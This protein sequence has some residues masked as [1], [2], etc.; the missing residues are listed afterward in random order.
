LKCR[1]QHEL[2]LCDAIAFAFARDAGLPPLDVWY[3]AACA[4]SLGS[5]ALVCGGGELELSVVDEPRPAVQ[6]RA[7]CGVQSIGVTPPEL[8]A[9]ERYADELEIMWLPEIGSLITAR[10]WLP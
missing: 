8:H 5:H 1:D 9:A 2:Q 4:V 3:V 6:L 10:R 7:R